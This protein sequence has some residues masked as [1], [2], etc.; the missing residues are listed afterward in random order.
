M[1]IL[2]LNSDKSSGSNFVSCLKY[3]A[4]DCKVYGTSTHPIRSLL[5]ETDQNIYVSEAQNQHPSKVID[6]ARKE[7]NVDFDLTYQSKSDHYMLEYSK[8][9]NRYPVFLPA[10]EQVVIY[11][12]KYLTYR[13]LVKKGFNVPYTGLPKN[14]EDLHEISRNISSNKFWVREKSGQGGK[15]SFKADS[16]EAISHVLD[17]RNGWGDYLVSKRIDIKESCTW[18]QRLSDDLS[19]GEMVSWIALYK[20]NDLIASQVRKR[21]YWEH[22]DLTV[23]G[24]TGYTGAN[25]TISNDYIHELSDKIARSFGSV[26][27]VMGIDYLVDDNGDPVATEIQASRFFTSTYFLALLGL[28]FPKLYIEAFND[29]PSLKNT[30]NPCKPGY[31]YIQRFGAKSKLIKR[32]KIMN[33]G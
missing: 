9:R 25:M 6:I 33:L 2:V 17:E 24:V 11:E 10:H 1:N 7:S 30:V 16:V 21:L 14:V 15:G 26:N 31:L 22:S 13:H 3:A 23:S 8:H 5:S 32:D 4:V 12:D 29:A 27:G 18:K 19:P 28:N 20:N